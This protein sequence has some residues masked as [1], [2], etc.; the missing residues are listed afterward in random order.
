MRSTA[1]ANILAK[2]PVEHESKVKRRLLRHLDLAGKPSGQGQPGW[3]GVTMTPAT[4]R[5][6]QEL[7]R[8]LPDPPA[9][10]DLRSQLDQTITAAA[11][12]RHQEPAAVADSPPEMGRHPRFDATRQEDDWTAT[13]FTVSD[14]PESVY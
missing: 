13:K 5:Q 7:R 6:L 4:V 3:R 1:A 12:P 9:T 8:Q 10:G 11:C 14:G 2:A